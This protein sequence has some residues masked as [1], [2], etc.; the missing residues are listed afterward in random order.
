MTRHQQ[1]VI[2]YSHKWLRMIQHD[3]L[4]I[5]TRCNFVQQPTLVAAFAVLQEV[6]TALER[7][8][9][10]AVCQRILEYHTKVNAMLRLVHAFSYTN[11]RRVLYIPS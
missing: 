6:S 5:Y 11:R 3:K 8:A 10:G 1:S 7:H 9:Q 2:S 4:Y